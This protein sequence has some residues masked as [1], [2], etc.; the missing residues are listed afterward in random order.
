MLVVSSGNNRPRWLER[1]RPAAGPRG[2]R[3][4]FGPCPSVALPILVTALRPPGTSEAL[5][6]Q[7]GLPQASSALHWGVTAGP[8]FHG[9]LT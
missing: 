7:A 2:P 5:L 1:G 8:P 3:V 4:G 6:P 9:V